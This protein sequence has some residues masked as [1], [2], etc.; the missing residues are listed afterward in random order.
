MP[1][2]MTAQVRDSGLAGL[3][4]AAR[5]RTRCYDGT[6]ANDQT[7][8]PHHRQEKQSPKHPEIEFVLQVKEADTRPGVSALARLI[9]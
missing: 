2:T 5:A 1:R 6:V 8:S 4:A 7:R 9:Q 3:R